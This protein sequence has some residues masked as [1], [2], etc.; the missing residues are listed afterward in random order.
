MTIDFEEHGERTVC[1]NCV[2]DP[3]LAKQIESSGKVQPCFYCND[4]EQ[5]TWPLSEVVQ[6][7]ETAF[8]QHYRRT[9]DEPNAL[10]S[11]MLRDKE[12]TYD[13]E[14]EGDPTDIAIQDALSC[15]E[16][17][18]DDLQKYL[19]DKHSD[20]DTSLGGY[21]CE[22]DSEAQY[23]AIMPSDGEWHQDWYR[24][25]KEL[26]SE[27]R[28]FNKSAHDYLTSIFS[29]IDTM[30]TSSGKPVIVVAGPQTEG[31]DAHEM[32]GFYRARVF[33]SDRKLLDAMKRPDL[34]LGP[35]PSEYAKAGRTN[36]HG[37]SVFY[38]AD[39][40]DGALAEVRPPVGSQ[41][42]MGRFDLKRPVRLLDFSALRSVREAG[43]IFDPQY[44]ERLSR[45]R[46]L[47]SMKD[48]INRPVMP[49]DEE[50]EYLA[51]QAVIDF[52]ANGLPVKLDG[53]LFP[54]VQTNEATVN[55]VLFHRS[56]KV[57]KLD[58]PKGTEIDA[59]TYMSTNEGADPWYSVHE[60]V[61]SEEDQA[62]LDAEAAKFPGL[63]SYVHDGGVPDEDLTLRL[64]M[65]S[66]QVMVVT[67]A[68]YVTDD[69]S[70]HRH[71][72]EI[73]NNVPF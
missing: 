24:F 69:H 73:Q 15:S 41:T 26:K 38:G 65:D 50:F 37:I 3:Y 22:F 13:F 12:S 72:S 40:A 21:E 49:T 42:L 27:T 9:S 23:E 10:Q 60:E 14:R 61:P 28:F 17:L 68:S 48:R 2:S 25:E 29:G 34:E 16:P 56:S 36:A 70:V 33:Y 6:W 58:L 19:E 18:A 7:V 67:K 64:D 52:L 45:A 54:S 66:L 43:S 31:E 8:E 30:K 32:T 11:M 71:R 44:A 63:L 20:W 51:T 57:E 5:P 46:F 62:K 35:P 4:D 47:R 39:S 1:D 59:S 55:V 53:V